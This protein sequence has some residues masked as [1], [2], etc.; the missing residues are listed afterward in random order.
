VV[1][2]A[3]TELTLRQRA[4]R[5]ERARGWLI[6]EQAALRR[7]ATLVARHASPDEIFATV[8]AEVGELL[9]A[10][11]AHIVRYEPDGTITVVGRWTWKGEGLPLGTRWTLQGRSISALVRQTGQPAR[12][13]TYEEAPGPIAEFLRNTGVHAAVGSPIVVDGR[14]WGAMIVNW[15]QPKKLPDD[16]EARLEDFTQLV[17]TAISNAKA[18]EELAASRARVVAAADET[19]RRLERDLHDG[20]QQRLVQLIL[21][22]RRI[23]AGVPGGDELDGQVSRVVEELADV[24]D[25]LREL[26]RGLHPALLSQGGLEPALKALARRSGVPVALNVQVG[27]RFAEAVETAAYYVVAEAMTNVVKHSRATVAHVDVVLDNGLLR[28][29][30]RDDGVGGADPARGSGLIGLTDRLAVLGGTIAVDSPT[31]G[32]TSLCAE[33]PVHE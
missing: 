8:A 25:A 22:M 13:E 14:L 17:A 11:L 9:D 21:D 3:A 2:A 7:V 23:Q 6:D 10:H 31:G 28:L 27:D 20:I 16:T 24:S 18:S 19:R 29:V 1:A 26:S 5:T 15:A 30:V 33:I 32:G 12:M 4:R